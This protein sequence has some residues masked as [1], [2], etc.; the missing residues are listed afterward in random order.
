MFVDQEAVD[1]FG[2]QSHTTL[3]Q[4]PHQ[5]L[6]TSQE[7]HPEEGNGDLKQFEETSSRL[8]APATRRHVNTILGREMPADL[9]SI[10]YA[11]LVAAGGSIGYFKSGSAASLYAGLAFGSILGVGAYMTS[12]NPSNYFLT[13]GTSSVLGGVM[14]FRFMRSGKFMPAGLIALMSLGMVLRFSVRALSDVQR[15]RKQP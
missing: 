9:V 2:D 7:H 1:Q 11:A 5:A 10:A 3:L 8:G 15:Y 14:G 6:V 12:V 4:T 13:L